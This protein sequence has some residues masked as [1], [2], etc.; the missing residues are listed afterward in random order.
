[1]GAQFNIVP[2][3]GGNTFSGTYFGSLAGEWSQGNNVDDTL[4]SY[5]IPE[6][7][8]IIKNWDTSFSMGG[9]ILKDRI[10]FYAVARTFGEYTDIAGRFGNLNAGQPHTLGIRRRSEHQVALGG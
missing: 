1:M 2:K 7:T 8:K 5:R 3:T 10:W 4:R 9:P 6:P